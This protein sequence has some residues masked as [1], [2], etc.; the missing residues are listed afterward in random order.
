MEPWKKKWKHSSFNAMFILTALPI[1]V[2]M[3]VIMLTVSRW[4][5]AHHWG[6]AY[7][8]PNP[9][10]VWIK[11]VGMFVLLDFL[12]YVYHVTVHWI[13]RFWRFHRVHH[14]DLKVDVSTTVREHPG[15]SVLRM[16]FLIGFVFFCGA[17][18]EVLLLR[19]TVQTVSNILSH[20]SLRLPG[21]FGT[22]CRWV[23]ITPNL[24]HVHHHYV[25]PYTNCNYGDVFSIWDRLFGTF[26]ELPREETV[27]GLDTHMDESVNASFSGTMKMPFLSARKD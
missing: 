9:S 15:E 10:S 14:S 6:L 2:G 24:H 23:F 27:F 11:Y 7:L 25:L 22:I 19:Q 8:L 17:S 12:D 13:A 3:A 16:C 4:T 18:P 5:G 21:R 1:Q 26:K 20:T